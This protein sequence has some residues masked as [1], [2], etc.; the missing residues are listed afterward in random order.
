MTSL[1]VLLFLIILLLPSMITEGRVLTQT[2]K[3]ATIFADQKTNHEADL[4]NPDP[5]EVQ[6]ALARIL[7]ALGE[8][9][10]LVKDQAN[11]GQQEFKLPKDFTGRS[12]CRSLGRIK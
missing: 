11:A 3:E 1:P 12:K 8:L 2:G 4:K 9:D 10:K 6:R 7:C 5:Q